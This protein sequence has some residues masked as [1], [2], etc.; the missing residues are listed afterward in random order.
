MNAPQI[1]NFEQHE[2]Q[3]I[4]IN[5]EP[6][7]IGKEIAELLGYTNSRKA[8]KDHVDPED[9]IILT[10]RIVTLE[11]MPNRGLAGIN[12]SGLYSLAIKSGLPSAKK[13]QR[14][15]T[16]EV[17]PSIRKQGAYLTD[18]KAMEI[19]TNP[20]S[21]ADLLLQAGEQL[22]QKD[23]VIQ[24]LE[25]K[26]LFFDAVNGSTNS[27]LVKDLS[28]LLKQKGINIGQNRL[29]RYLRENGYLGKGNGHYNKPTQRTLD[30]GL[31]EYRENFHTNSNGE[32]VT[33]FTPLVTGKGQT[34]FV[35]KFLQTV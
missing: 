20:D 12:E 22:K 33:R 35:N 21:L 23:I 18:Q 6:Y 10:S 25:P 15:I 32:I 5:D 31:F 27:C 24:Q 4:L 34:Y 14:W 2:V 7:F 1:F 8:L 29:F 19:T 17:L 30:R 26:A 3:T 16:K 13:F 11:N 28:V 9:K